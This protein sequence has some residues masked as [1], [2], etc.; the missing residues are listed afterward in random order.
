[1]S[2]V[3]GL[4]LGVCVARDAPGEGARL[5]RSCR[6]VQAA[7]PSSS[8]SRVARVPLRRVLGSP[9]AWASPALQTGSRGGVLGMRCACQEALCVQQGSLS[10]LLALQLVVLASTDS[11]VLLT[12]F[13]IRC[14]SHPLA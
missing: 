2:G 13:K 3:L 1:M 12:W 5:A 10:A 11:S 4:E 14:V 7:N 9:V 8:G 6:E